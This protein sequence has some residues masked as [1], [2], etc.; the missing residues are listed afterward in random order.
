MWI[1]IYNCRFGAV[2]L[3]G[4]IVLYLKLAQKS[5]AIRNRRY[6][7]YAYNISNKLKT[8]KVDRVE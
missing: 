8:I 6:H 4:K 2:I 7:R 1:D 3:K 5:C